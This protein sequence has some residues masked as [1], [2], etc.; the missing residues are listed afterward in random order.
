VRGLISVSL[1]KSFAEIS[2]LNY[3]NYLFPSFISACASGCG[4]RAIFY[5]D[6]ERLKAGKGYYK[7]NQLD[8]KFSGALWALVVLHPAK[9]MHVTLKEFI[10]FMDSTQQLNKVLHTRKRL[11]PKKLKL[12][13]IS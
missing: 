5:K 4:K 13:G 2:M 8:F 12:V 10:G 6:N 7:G 11:H 1:V 9:H 3:L